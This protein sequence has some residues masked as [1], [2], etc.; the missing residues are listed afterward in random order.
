MNRHLLFSLLLALCACGSGPGDEVVGETTQDLNTNGFVQLKS[1]TTA[2]PQTPSS[3]TA[4]FASAQTAGN[5]NVVS[6]C[7]FNNTSTI[8]SVADTKGN[9]YVVASPLKTTSLGPASC[10]M[11]A[12]FHIVAAAANS[13]TITVTF[14]GPTKDPDLIVA[15]YSGI[16]G[17]DVSAA[18]AGTV[19]LASSGNATTT[20]AGDLIVGSNYLSS[21]T[22]GPG[23]GFTKRTITQPDGDIFEDELAGGPGAY[24]AT[25][26]TGGGWWVM[27]MAAFKTSASTDAGAEGGSDGGGDAAG[28]SDSGGSDAS[29]DA[30]MDSSTDAALEA[31]LGMDGGDASTGDGGVEDASDALAPMDAGEAG[32]LPDVDGESDGGLLDG[33]TDGGMVLGDSAAADA[34]VWSPTLVQHVSGSNLRGNSLSSPYCYYLQ[35][36]APAQGGNAIVVG[37]TWKG[38]ATLLVTDDMG[39]T[40]TNNEVFLDS[41]DGQSI[42]VASAFGVSSGARA[43]SVCFSSNPGGWVQPMA[44]E[45]A[46]VVSIDGAAGTSGSGTTASVGL[47]AGSDMLYQVVYTPGGP[48]SSFTAGSGGSLLSADVLDGF[49][50]Q[51]GASTMTLGSST[52]WATSAVLLHAGSA[53]SIPSGMRIVRELHQNIPSG[54]PAG[55]SGAFANPLSL[56]FPS[57]GNL[58]VAVIAGGCG[59]G[60]SPKV[61]S[62]TDSASN[63]WVNPLTEHGGDAYSQ[64]FYVANAVTSSSL[65]VSTSWTYTGADETAIVWDVIGASTTPLD[66]AVGGSGTAGGGN[67]TLPFT[68]PTIGPGE[69]IFV[70]TPWDFDTAGGLMGGAGAYLATMTTSGEPHDGPFPI[71]ENNGWG[72][73]VSGTSPTSITWVPEFGGEEFGNY[74]AVTAAFRSAP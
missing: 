50:G 36:P 13:N 49:S 14:S 2:D 63:S 54:D 5:A 42:G 61:T 52:H 10:A 7:F 34:G 24:A 16:V 31:G 59:C 4:K 17:V 68:V 15:E 70:G 53:G 57:S 20:Q 72:H 1:T 45:F 18:A 19:D 33:T 23:A 58:L 73:L 8:K 56:Q 35:L 32:D 65:T 64:L 51:Y 43:L 48:P 74:S 12:A 37:A 29:G 21:S 44:T 69:L 55:G 26:P 3:T 39:D 67:L 6:I 41:T 47:S 27:Q 30:A 28:T 60:E 25:A 38:S 9:S 11:Y 46:N 66:V 22:S 40:Y 71:D 62:M